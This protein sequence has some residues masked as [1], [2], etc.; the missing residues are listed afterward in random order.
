MVNSQYTIDCTGNCVTGDEIYFTRSI[1][2]GSYKNPQF[3]GYE[4]IEAKI[5]GDS[6]SY[7][8]GYH[9]FDLTRVDTGKK[10]RIRGKNLYANGVARKP[11]AN[12]GHRVAAIDSKRERSLTNKQYRQLATI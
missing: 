6:Y 9:W 5:V 3:A 1:F 11:W 7:A 4:A 12:E 8:T 10:F 2:T